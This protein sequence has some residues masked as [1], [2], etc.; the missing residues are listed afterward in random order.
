MHVASGTGNA[1]ITF[2]WDGKN[3]SG[4]ICGDLEV[5]QDV[6]EC[7]RPP[8][9]GRGRSR[10]H[11]HRAADPGYAAFP[12]IKMNLKVSRSEESWAPVQKI[13]DYK[14]GP[15]GYVVDKVNVPRSC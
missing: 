4:A 3:V 6:S 2:M 13:L 7:V 9:P 8:L 10:P 11:R 15:C 14:T 1:T 12:A 5:T